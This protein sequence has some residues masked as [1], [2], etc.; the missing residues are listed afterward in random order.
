MWRC[1]RAAQRV[2]LREMDAEREAQ[3]C[4]A[5][6]ERKRI[7]TAMLGEDLG[8]EALQD[9]CLAAVVAMRKNPNIRKPKAY[10]CAILYHTVQTAIGERIRARRHTSG[11]LVYL[12]DPTPANEEAVI[13]AEQRAIADG[14]LAVMPARKREILE[15]SYLDGESP[16]ET[17][18]EMG[19]TMTQYRLLKSRSKDLFGKLGREMCAA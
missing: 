16:A 9:A 8:A 5:I 10:A 14:V 19:L 17:C 7:V 12:T 4:E 15:R 11:A 6:Y 3:A 2:G 13:R 1:R 18:F